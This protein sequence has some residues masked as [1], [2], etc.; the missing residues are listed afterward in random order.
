MGFKKHGF[1]SDEELATAILEAV[2][3]A[4]EE[5]FRQTGESFYYFALITSGEA[6]APIVSAWSREKLSMVADAERPLVK[7]SYADSPYCDFD[8][9]AFGKVRR[10]FDLRPDILLLDEPHR[11]L[12]YLRR[13]AAMEAALSQADAAGLFGRGGVR[14][15][16]VINVEVMPPDGSNTERAVRLNPP[17]FLREWMDEAAE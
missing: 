8:S 13:L 12:E 1:M 9:A 10:L 11:S 17:A 16:M 4:A 14:E 6:H 3:T 5:L 2:T 15:R 7:W